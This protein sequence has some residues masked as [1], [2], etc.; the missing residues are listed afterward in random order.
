ML[1]HKEPVYLSKNGSDM[2][3]FLWSTNDTPGKILNSFELSNVRLWSTAP[4]WRTIKKFKAGVNLNRSEIW[5]I[6]KRELL[7]LK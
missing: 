6:I 4:D 7:G 3:V 5:S 2:I 1:F